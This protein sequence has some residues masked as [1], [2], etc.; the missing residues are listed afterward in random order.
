MLLETLTRRQSAHAAF[1]LHKH[2][3]TRTARRFASLQKDVICL[4]N[5]RCC[6]AL[7]QCIMSS[8][9]AKGHVITK[10]VRDQSYHQ[11]FPYN[12][13]WACDAM[14]LENTDIDACVTEARREDRF[15]FSYNNDTRKCLIYEHFVENA[16][17]ELMDHGINA[18]WC[19]SNNVLQNAI[20]SLGTTVL[21]SKRR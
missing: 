21:R 10:I 17:D 15:V 18:S 4:P 2:Q 11:L 5:R 16:Y 12:A 7:P 20:T 19:Y 3:E 14:V 9:E 8:G 13:F 6:Y 1:L